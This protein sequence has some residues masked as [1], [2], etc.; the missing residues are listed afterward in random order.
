MK[1]AFFPG[2]NTP[3]KHYRSY[4]PHFA[5][6][7]PE[8][9]EENIEVIL[10][11]SRGIDDA[12]RYCQKYEINPVPVIIS[13]DGIDIDIPHNIK[14]ISFC[15]EHKQQSKDE[16]YLQVIYYKSQSHYP[17]MIKN[18][19]DKIVEKIQLLKTNK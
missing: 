10:C 17:Y 8:C 7:T 1:L 13:M 11:H 15:P 9:K 14:V 12:I 4:F 5:L 16:K 3:L 18:I 6:Y 19:R 2:K